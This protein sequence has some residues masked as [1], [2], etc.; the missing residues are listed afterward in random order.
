MA[1]PHGVGEVWAQAAWEVYW[2]L[3]H[4]HGFDANLYDA[5][6]V[7]GNQRMMLY[8]NEGLKNTACSPTFT[9]VRDGIIQA[10][11][12]NYGGEDVCFLWEAF[13]GFGLGAD[14]VSGGPFSTFA[15]NGFEVPSSCL[16]GPRVV[17]PISGSVLTGS[18]VTFDWTPDQD[19]VDEWEL[20]IGSSRGASDIYASGSLP[21]GTLSAM[22]A[23]LPVDGRPVFVRLNYLV[24]TEWGFRDALYTA[25]LATPEIVDPVPGAV[26]DASMVTFTWDGFGLPVE[27]WSLD[28]GSAPASGDFYA[29]GTLTS[30]VLTV[31]VTGLPT[32]GRTIYAR[33]QY[34]FDGNWKFVDASYV[35]ADIVPT[36]TTPT[37]GSTLSGSDVTFAWDT[38]GS[39]VDDWVLYVGSSPG[40]SDV[41]N[42]GPL[43]PDRSSIDVTD[44]PTNGAP[45]YVR[46]RYAFRFAWSSIDYVY[47]ASDLAPEILS[48]VPG[49]VLS[50]ASVPF[51]WTSHGAA[52]TAWI[53][54]IGS[55]PGSSNYFYSGTLAG[56]VVSATATG[57]PTDSRA[58]Y[59]RL[60]YQ[61]G[62]S[63]VS[64]Y[65]E[66]IA[67]DLVPL[68]L[69]PAPGTVLSSADVSFTWTAN[70]SSVSNW[71]LGIGSAPGVSNYYYSGTLAGS[72]QSVFATGLPMNSSTLHVRLRYLSNAV[73]RTLD[74]VHTSAAPPPT[75]TVP[76]PGTALSDTTV[77]FG[78]A[79][80][81]SVVT[82]W[83]LDVGS[84]L[85][86]ADIF[87]GGLLPAATRMLD[88]SSLPTDGR[89]LSVRLKFRISG[90]WSFADFLYTA[91]LREPAMT[92][93]ELGSV[94]PGPDV[95]FQWSTHGAL[96][97][98]WRLLVGNTAGSG[99]LNDSG[100]LPATTLN[101]N[102]SDLPT[103]GRDIHV[104]LEYIEGGASL[105]KDYLY[106]A[107]VGIPEIKSPAP[108]S[109][110][111]SSDVTF[112]WTS[113][114]APVTTWILYVG[115]SPESSNIYYSG[116]LTADVL[117][118]EITGPP[119]D[120]RTI[121]AR[122]RY[123]L[124]GAWQ[125]ADFQY[126]AADLVPQVQAPAP[127]S[128]LAGSTAAFSWTSNGAPVTRWIL[129]VGTRTGSSNVYYS[130]T[131]SS[132][133]TT[134]TV[135]R[136]P[137][138]SSTIYVRL[139][140][141][142]N[143]AWRYTD[144]EY[145]TADLSP[146]LL[147]P[148]P[149][150]VL[151]GASATFSWTDGGA[152]VTRWILYVG[153][154]L[155]SSNLHYSGSLSST[156]TP[157][158]VTGLPTDSRTIYVRLR[159]ILNGYW[160]HTDYQY[161][162]A[163]LVPELVAPT[164]GGTLAGANQSF[165]GTSNGAAVSKWILYVGTSLGSSNLFYSGDLVSGVLSADVSGLP[166]DGRAIYVR[167]RY[168]ANGA[169]KSLDYQYT[170]ASAP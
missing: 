93:P 145:T 14:A 81:G 141:I 166:T 47:T 40:S 143:G 64:L 29:S 115:T 74:Y 72:V 120:S 35:T 55:V 153:T 12:D 135:T 111:S 67:A 25:D 164:P 34:F 39:L 82:D 97:T 126:T 96:V 114:D 162:A 79:D 83:E 152:A 155:G 118:A 15:I 136:I 77:S 169:W 57:I 45:I 37:P 60:R 168:L 165:T 31:D 103:D 150:S 3:V 58:I 69:T 154:S 142:V 5:M 53:L 11:I 108:G 50:G 137:T 44:I 65:E 7:A 117:T 92:I 146:S 84:T 158:T 105:F 8:V 62:S 161:T 42:S 109:A 131:L 59:M 52:V 112:S 125:S 17:S 49:S 134:A 27:N 140:Y 89:Q 98:G 30:A 132:S 107:G 101:R 41:F 16:A 110:F 43:G 2:T 139:R 71:T 163:D 133:V 20:D 18:T 73:W 63:W 170:A 91:D 80:N 86:A 151:T 104:R 4:L 66:Y 9:D 56:N 13:A 22:V 138:D 61:I 147:T 124:N 33:L 121:Y 24:G 23:T 76:L 148:I 149:G 19:V 90:V 6:G 167:L 157:A 129:Y 1:V 38:N 70:G 100:P 75:M 160:K 122:L 32:D 54:E 46:L 95:A 10:A 28:I 99:D 116:S 130:G 26:L 156:I 78:W 159:Y 21:G 144:Y 127:G 51:S 68:L 106:T 36:L 123:L 113:N 87:D 88:V 119:T 85:G 102:V 128:V 94:L 48:P